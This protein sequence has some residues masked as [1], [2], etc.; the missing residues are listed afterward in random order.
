MTQHSKTKPC[1]SC[2]TEISAEPLVYDWDCQSRTAL[3]S[4][5]CEECESAERKEYERVE[6]LQ[7]L[8]TQWQE[9]A[10]PVYQESDT[11]RFPAELQ[12]ALA[13]FDPKS[14][15]GFGFRGSPGTCKTRTA[16]AMLK[17][18]HFAGQIVM[19][20]RSTEIAD[21]AA[22]QWNSRPHPSNYSTVDKSLT[23]GQAN[24]DRL[25]A[26]G[27]CRWLLID[28]IGKEKPTERT[29]TALFEILEQRTSH[30][31]PTIWTTNM[32]AAELRSRHTLDRSGPI[33]RRLIEFAT[34]I[35]LK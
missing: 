17:K 3:P 34:L 15:V 7:R 8:T 35:T 24:K 32:S 29:E 27:R 13:K 5:I 19:A 9:I 33:L 11:S 28:D 26:F 1:R 6:K 16:F 10:P 22:N 4:D 21:L 2:G 30:L 25:A 12:E 20:T 23:I 31:L 18:A 14:T